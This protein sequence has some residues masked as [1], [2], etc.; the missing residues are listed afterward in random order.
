LAGRKSTGKGVAAPAEKQAQKARNYV[1]V[2]GDAL[3]RRSLRDVQFLA[4]ILHKTYYSEHS[5]VDIADVSDI[6]L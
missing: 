6:L 5:I 1:R 3:P 2:S 4:E